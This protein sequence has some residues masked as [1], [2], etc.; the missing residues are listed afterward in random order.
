MKSLQDYIKEEQTELFKK[1]GVFF[2]YSSKQFDEATKDFPEGTEYV[3]VGVG[4]FLPRENVDE[5]ASAHS[6]LVHKGIAKDLEENGK[7]AIIRR[8]LANYECQLTGDLSEVAEVL[9]D[10]GITL[11]EIKVGY[12]KFYQECVENDW[13]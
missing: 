4:T 6:M 5:F 2:A 3:S 12:G 13:F 10:Y 8:E 9:E 7:D 11:D 1:Y